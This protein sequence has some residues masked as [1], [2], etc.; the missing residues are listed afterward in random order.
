MGE[1]T[2]MTG[3]SGA[4]KPGGEAWKAARREEDQR[5]HFLG[6]SYGNVRDYRAGW[7]AG[8]RAHPDVAPTTDAK[9][10]EL[11]A[12]AGDVLDCS[13]DYESGLVRTFGE[14]IVTA[15]KALRAALAPF[16]PPSP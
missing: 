11:V 16:T 1:A 5:Q 3:K 13:D 2:A 15:K 10:A 9:V 14:R 12:A 7:S 8:Y 4:R 6:E